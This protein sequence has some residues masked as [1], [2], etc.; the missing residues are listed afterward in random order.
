MLRRLFERIE[1][2]PE[3][4]AQAVGI[5]RGETE[6]FTVFRREI[7]AS[8]YGICEILEASIL[9]RKHQLR[10]QRAFADVSR[11][12]VAQK[13]R[14]FHQRFPIRNGLL[15]R[16]VARQADVQRNALKRLARRYKA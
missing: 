10:A 3:D 6:R 9:Q 5:P 12:R 14:Q 13:A 2:L 4:F 8:V 7:G 15:T 1:R 11:L 16:L